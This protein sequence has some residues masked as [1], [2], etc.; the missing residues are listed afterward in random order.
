MQ[1]LNFVSVKRGALLLLL[2]L[3]PL[4][5]TSCASVGT[6]SLW[7]PCKHPPIDPTTDQGVAQGL[8]AYQR[9]IDTCNALNGV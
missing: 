1:L 3:L 2:G 4:S 8:L 9:E 5:L 7:T 6:A